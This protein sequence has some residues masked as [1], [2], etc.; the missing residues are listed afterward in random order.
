MVIAALAW[1]LKSWLALLQPRPAGRQGLLT[2]EFKKFLA[3]EV[4]LLP[5]QVVLSGAAFYIGFAA[6]G[7]RGWTCCA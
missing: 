1:N 5:F 7:T 2:M 4:L 3:E 6:A